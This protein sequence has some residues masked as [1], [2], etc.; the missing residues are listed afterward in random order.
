V[1]A[2]IDQPQREGLDVDQIGEG[3]PTNTISPP[4][5]VRTYV[6]GKSPEDGGRG[7]VTLVQRPLAFFGKLELFSV[8]GKALDTVLAEG[9]SI[10]EL[11]EE[12]PDR[13]ADELR[14]QDIQDADTFVKAISVLAMHSPELFKE[15]YCVILQV[16]REHRERVMTIMS[17]PEDLGGLSDDQGFEIMDTFIAQN[18]ELLKRF[19]VDRIIPLF[20]RMQSKRQDGSASS[21]PSSP[22]PRSTRKRSKS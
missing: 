15:L 3:D 7:V 8:L 16:P 12:T 1:S 22:T 19:F 10:G 17:D 2:T 5:A 20:D 14:L 9:I 13:P 4:G 21:K 6:V 18:G 11:L